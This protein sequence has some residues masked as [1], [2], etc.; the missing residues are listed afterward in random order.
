M[1]AQ[2]AASGSSGFGP[3]PLPG[4]CA[5]F[6]Q[7]KRRFC[8]M[9]PALGRRF[10]GEHGQQE[11]LRPGVT[12]GAAWAPRFC[13]DRPS[14]QPCS[15][16]AGSYRFGICSNVRFLPFPQTPPTRWFAILTCFSAAFVQ[17]EH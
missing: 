17:Q 5:F 16:T 4:R 1:A 14:V 2:D 8:K 11:V 9:V 10:C 15:G 6:V 12:G 7:R 3:G 13:T